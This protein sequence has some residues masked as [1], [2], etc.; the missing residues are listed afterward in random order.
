MQTRHFDFIDALR[1]IAA[2][3]V[4]LYHLPH[5]STSS[6]N[7]PSW[8]S[9]I[10][11]AGGT[12]VMLFFVL[13]AFT[14]CLSMEQRSSHELTPTLNYFI[15]RFFRIA[16]LFY[17]FI[18]ITFVRDIVI[19]GVWHSFEDV[20]K[21]CLFIFNLIPGSEQG[22]VW[23]SW[24]IG[25]E[26]LFYVMFP[27]LF[28]L[29]DNIGK[30]SAFFLASLCV[31]MAWQSFVGQHIQNQDEASIYYQISIIH[32]LPNFIVGVIAYHV[33]NLIVHN[34][35]H[36]LGIGYFLISLSLCSYIGMVYGGISFYAFGD[37]TTVQSLIYSMLLIGLS[38]TSAK[39]IVNPITRKL[40]TIS[41]SI[42]LCHSTIIYLLSPVFAWSASNFQGGIIS[43]LI[44]IAICMIAILPISWLT[45]KYIERPG[46][47]LGRVVIKHLN[48]APNATPAL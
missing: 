48:K 1:G 45:Y 10:T 3:Y 22:F 40:G 9:P 30:A 34:K 7:V 35:A 27:L 21:S 46:N 20:L 47:K 2:F 8:L 28:K 23:A 4:V 5:L 43:Y 15:R 18:V 6:V 14:L 25:V 11:N 41:Y 39:V 16:P 29:L 13:S 33:Y 17:F 42:Y 37:L 44:D 19:F 38:I 26:M 32:H 24:T 36:N 12:G 31:R